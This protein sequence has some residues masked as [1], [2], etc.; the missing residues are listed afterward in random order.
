MS[1]LKMPL[2]EGFGPYTHKSSWESKMG[3]EFRGGCLCGE[4]T[5]QVSG[6][7]YAFHWCHCS[8]CRKDTGSAHAANLFARPG[9]I[10]W[11]TGL[12]KV[13]RFDLPDARRFAKAFCTECGSPVPYLNRSGTQLI[14]PAG[15]LDDPP[16]TEPDDNIHWGSRARW[17]EAG[18]NAP[19]FD[20]EPEG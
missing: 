11:L 13:K 10:R 3:E 2:N 20:A 19:R 14:I 17:Y 15:S 4:T 7:F 18:L 1:C 8:R 5:F 9:S 6:P 16:D 12:Q